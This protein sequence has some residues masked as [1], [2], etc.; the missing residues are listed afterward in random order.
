LSYYQHIDTSEDSSTAVDT[1]K[2]QVLNS[3]GGILAT[4]ST[5]SN[6]NANNGY[7]LIS[8]NMSAYA[9]ETIKIKWTGTET[10][11]GGGTTDF[12]LDTTAFKVS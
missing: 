1:L 10:D 7:K 3:S 9:G 11:T 2:L 5:Y 12:T 4:L 8:V 6:L